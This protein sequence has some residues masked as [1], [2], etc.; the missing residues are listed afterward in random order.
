MRRAGPIGSED[1]GITVPLRAWH[2][3]DNDVVR[4][5]LSG[6]VAPQELHEETTL[7][8]ELGIR[9]NCLRFLSDYSH[10]TVSF[11]MLDLFRDVEMHDDHG[12]PKGLARIAVVPPGGDTMVE[13]LRFY[14]S[15]ATLQ[16]WQCRGFETLDAALAWLQE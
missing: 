15:L 13:L 16:G 10:A 8:A 2:D 9:H 14:E 7:A 1:W 12:V 6:S 3:A 4:T 11:S 5:E